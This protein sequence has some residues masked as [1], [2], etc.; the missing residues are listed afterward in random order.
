MQQYPYA[1]HPNK[2]GVSMPIGYVAA[3]PYQY[4][5]HPAN[6]ARN[7][8]QP[9][10]GLPPP[11]MAMMMPMIANGGVG[12]I[13]MHHPLAQQFQYYQPNQ[14]Y[15]STVN[16][17]NSI[18]HP[19]AAKNFQTG[20]TTTTTTTTTTS[21]HAGIRDTKENKINASSSKTLDA[22]Q[23]QGIHG[24]VQ[25]TDVNELLKY[26]GTKLKV[27]KIYRISKSKSSALVDDSSD[28][29]NEQ[30]YLNPTRLHA[31]KQTM[32]SKN[33]TTAATFRHQSTLSSYDRR[34]SSGSD[35]S[36][37]RA[38]RERERM[39]NKQSKRK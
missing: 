6:A 15:Y 2:S 19:G 33:T 24:L 16:A 34:Y 25:N 9:P 20:T 26:K 39:Q 27:S 30:V 31:T 23:N 13:P 5:H 12:Q 18:N 17:S 36:E 10:A 7:F 22:G 8:R 29:E 4:G 11:P 14:G 37:C 32:S 38:E 3:V 1:P 35:C 21:K 28:D